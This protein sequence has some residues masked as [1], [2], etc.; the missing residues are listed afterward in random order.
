MEESL[1]KYVESN[2]KNKAILTARRI[3]LDIKI[4]CEIIVCYYYI[5]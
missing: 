3:K 1:G 4:F 5:L 2:L